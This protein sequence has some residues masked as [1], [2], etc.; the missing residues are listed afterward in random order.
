MATDPSQH[1]PVFPFIVGSGRSGTTLVRAIFSSHPDLA[2]CHESH[3]IPHLAR[4]RYGQGASMNR[5]RLLAD[6]F[7]DPNFRRMGFSRDEVRAAIDPTSSYAEAVRRIFGLFAA[8][9]GKPR[10]GDKTP[11]YVQHLPLLARLFPEARFL[12]VIR[13]GRDVAASLVE[14]R[15]GPES[16]GEA[17]IYW[18]K[19][20]DRGRRAGFQLGPERYREVRY[21]DLIGDAERIVSS[22]CSFFHLTFDERM[23]RYFEHSEDWIPET[24]RARA[25]HQ[26]L[27][28]PMTKG[29]R[30]WR[31]QMPAKEVALFEALAGAS[32]D[33]FGYT[34]AAGHPGLGTRRAAVSASYGWLLKRARNLAGRLRKRG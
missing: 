4:R 8:H 18:K 11:N 31:Q 9:H 3:F 17:A 21:E 26:N 28:K 33:A 14:Q 27:V 10:Y 1:Q 32:L 7:A 12:H 24:K 5:E 16:V 6:L 25:H 30:D 15:F 2:V 29:L 19:C 22:L 23:L 13:D 20:V 34:R